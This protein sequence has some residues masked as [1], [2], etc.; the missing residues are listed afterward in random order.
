MLA[1]SLYR[2]LKKASDQ[3]IPLKPGKSTDGC[4]LNNRWKVIINQ[5]IEIDDL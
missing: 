1:N 3:V 2:L 4:E 5:E